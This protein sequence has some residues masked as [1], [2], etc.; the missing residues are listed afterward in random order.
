MARSV[1]TSPASETLTPS[2]TRAAACLRLAGV[3]RL[4]APTWSSLPQ[5][6]QFESSV[7]QPSYWALLGAGLVPATASDSGLG[8]RRCGGAGGCCPGWVALWF[9]ADKATT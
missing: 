6:P 8:P 3:I 2:F 7:F 5:R 1:L 4:L 9:C